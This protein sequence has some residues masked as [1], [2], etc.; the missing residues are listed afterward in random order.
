MIV[1]CFP[2]DQLQNFVIS[3]S[4][5]MLIIRTKT[6]KL[7]IPTAIQNSPINT[8][9]EMLIIMRSIDK[10]D[11]FQIEMYETLDESSLAKAFAVRTFQFITSDPNERK[12]QL[13]ND[14]M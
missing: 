11:K 6:N 7:F 1:F 13:K 4:Q 5:L 2:K 10:L 8:Q 14:I 3:L 12:K 9:T